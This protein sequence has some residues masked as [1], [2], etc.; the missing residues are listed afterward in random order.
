[1]SSVFQSVFLLLA[2][3]TRQELARQVKYLKA[4]NEI[5]R[6]RLPKRVDV[7]SRERNR[8]IRLGRNLGSRVIQELVTLVSPK[9]F[10]RWLREASSKPSVGPKRKTGRPRTPEQI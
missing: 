5:L 9:T 1:M 6:S 2:S 10:L 4:E 8:L 7:T 3:A